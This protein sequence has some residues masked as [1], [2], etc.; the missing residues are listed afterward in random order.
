MHTLVYIYLLP[1]DY[2]EMSLKKT[3]A[4]TD[5]KDSNGKEI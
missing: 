3:K 1:P 4:R 5:A 2:Y